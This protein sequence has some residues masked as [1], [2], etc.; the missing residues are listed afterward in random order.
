MS[1]RTTEAFRAAFNS[2]PPDIQERAREAFDR[3]E[4]DPQHPSLQFKKVHSSRPIYSV[5]VTLSYRALAIQSNEHWLWFW[6]GSHSAYDDLL[7]RL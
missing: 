5:R 4:E 1:S 3:F 7:K 2:L 6:I